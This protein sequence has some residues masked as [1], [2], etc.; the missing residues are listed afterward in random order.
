M[1]VLVN[2]V[3]GGGGV[4]VACVVDDDGALV[5]DGVARVGGLT[6]IQ[7]GMRTPG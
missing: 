4:W 7:R 3:R 1:G 5:H 2:V 6:R